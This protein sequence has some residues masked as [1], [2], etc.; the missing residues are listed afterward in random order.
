MPDF[1]AHAMWEE[2]AEAQLF[3]KSFV[4]K[5][6]LWDVLLFLFVTPT[7]IYILVPATFL[8]DIDSSF[9]NA[10]AQAYCHKTMKEHQSSL[11][12]CLSKEEEVQ[13]MK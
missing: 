12:I 1:E 7:F 6:P 4:R 10:R 13:D 9:D 2:D 5:L 3:G 8:W 11:I